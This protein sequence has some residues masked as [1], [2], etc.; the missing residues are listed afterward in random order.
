MNQEFIL[1]KLADLMK[2]DEERA[3][4]EFAWLRLMSRMKYDGYQDFLAGMRFIESFA[5]W[6]Q[7]FKADE[8]ETAFQFV[9]KKLVFVGPAE[10]H[11]LVELFYPE[12]VQPRLV[13]KVAETLH[14]PQYR[15]WADERATLLY[16]A[17]LR[18][19]LFIE[20]SDGARIDI[21][22]RANAGIINNEQIVTAPRINQH[23]WK[24][25]LD[26]L[27]KATG[28]VEER[29]AFVYL[30][31]DFVGSGT[32]LL[33]KEDGNWK[34]KLWRFWDDVER[35]GVLGTHFDQ[36]WTVCVHHYLASHRAHETIRER[37]AE[38]RAAREKGK[39]FDTVEFTHGMLLP[40]DLPI[41]L[42]D[43]PDLAQLIERYY[44]DSIEDQHMKKGG[45]D[46]RLGFGRSALP[47]VL[48]H[49]TPN[50]AIALLWAETPGED[51]K[52]PMRPLFRRRQR[53]T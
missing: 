32:T 22:R 53:H 9:R 11:H 21:Y 46:A 27:R 24:E 14:I 28:N 25:L 17:L 31:D 41:K 18:K 6:L 3:R 49:N 36:G 4:K 35:D 33:R 40:P 19:T 37:D 39:W 50:N 44:D 13:R 45:V 26:D 42:A 30:V 38:V 7:Q 1:G 20:L 12:T 52:H 34:G 10:M 15:V 29:F 2:W 47:L 5:A 43:D 23:K 51:G 8:R 16:K 48:E